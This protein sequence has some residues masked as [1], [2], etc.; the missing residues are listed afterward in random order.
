MRRTVVLA[1]VLCLAAALSIGAAPALAADGCTCH[2]AVPPIGGAPAAHA[3][4]VASVTDCTT[5]HKGMTV[6]HPQLVKPTLYI[7]KPHVAG[8]GTDVFGGLGRPWLPLA[9]VVVYVQTKEP[10]GTVYTDAGKL[11]TDARGFYLFS[12]GAAI[13]PVYDRV[14]RA[15]SQGLAGPPVVM[16]AISVPTVARPMPT[17]TLRLS[18]LTRGAVRLGHAV[19]VAGKVTPT[20]MAGQK[21]RLTVQ[22]RNAHFRWSYRWSGKHRTAVMRTISATGAYSWKYTPKHLGLY[23]VKAKIPNTSAYND[24][25]TDWRRFRVK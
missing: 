6:P 20:D 15:I 7:G 1:I 8:L 3:P 5:C 4:L 10:T 2:T 25:L 19:S 14:P 9:G 16:P 11:K 12:L 21:V 17:L 18:G 13:P 24:Q 22:K 23:R